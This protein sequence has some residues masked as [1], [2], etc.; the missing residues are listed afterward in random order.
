MN[1]PLTKANTLLS[2]IIKTISLVWKA[3]RN[4][5]TVWMILL[6]IEGVL[7]AATV[8]LTR[9][10][11]NSL[12]AATGAGITW[13]KIQTVLIP[14]ALMAGVMLLTQLLGSLGEWIRTAQSEFIRDYISGLVHKQSMTIDI[15]CY[16][17]SDY[18]DYLNRARSGAGNHS[19]SLLENTGNLIKNSITLLTM[20]AVLIPYGLALPIILAGS[21]IPAF[22]VV[23]RLNK[24][25]HRW[26]H[27]TTNDRRWLQYYEVLLTESAF[28][29][30]IRLFGLGSYF[31]LAY[32][33]LRT[34]LRGE[35]IKLIREQSLGRFAAGVITLLLSTTGIVWMGRKVLLGTLTLGDLALFYQA[36]EQGQGLVKAALSNLGKIYKNSLYV[37]DL[38]HF[39]QLEAKVIDSPQPKSLPEKFNQGIRLRNLTFRYP[40]SERAVLENFN[41]HIPA[42][43]IVAIVGDNGAGKSTL[44]K[45]LCRF[46]DP[47]SGSVEIDGTNVRDF[48]LEQLRKNITVLFQNPIP[49]YTSVSQNIGLGDLSAKQTI[50]EIQT[51]AKA[52]GIDETITKLPK[53]YDSMLGKWFPNGNDLSGGQWQRLALARS[54]FRKA[55]LIILDEPTSAMDPW[56]EF[57]WLERFRKLA[58]NRTAVVITHRFTLA[59]RADIIHVM[60]AG[61]IVES[62]SHDEL[63]ALNGLYAESWK[64]QMESSSNSST[65]NNLYSSTQL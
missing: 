43:K 50:E 7:P 33:K 26:W 39:L 35:N 30:E 25:Y 23:L 15:A 36:F 18:H 9:Q 11:V 27:K 4:W 28:A 53:G 21:A 58:E 22:Y 13:E 3:S 45:L 61:K 20:V 19:L 42:G 17:S 38:F 2:H 44:I 12:V 52:A 16:E 54:F 6:F 59:M 63:L 14:F 64:T 31:Q 62:G 34:R 48:S 41:L 47:A 46:Y 29:A 60:R 8:Y 49:Y 37:S 1:N 57:D 65:D 10:L 56:A 32:Q 51:A 55:Q 5:T 40:G 24:R